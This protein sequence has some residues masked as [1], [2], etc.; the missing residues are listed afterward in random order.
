MPK[1]LN[2]RQSPMESLIAENSDL[3]AENRR[4]KGLL[5]D[6]DPKRPKSWDW[7]ETDPTYEELQEEHERLKNDVA[8]Q[9]Q[10]AAL[11]REKLCKVA[12]QLGHDVDELLQDIKEITNDR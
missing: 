4:L 12:T 3:H 10:A 1:T 2:P 7:C 5:D 9:K 6:K 11:L 8:A